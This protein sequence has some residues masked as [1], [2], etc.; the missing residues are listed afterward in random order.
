MDEYDDDGEEEEDEVDEEA[1]IKDKKKKGIEGFDKK[2]DL[3][4]SLADARKNA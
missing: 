4:K 2:G 1:A 3:S